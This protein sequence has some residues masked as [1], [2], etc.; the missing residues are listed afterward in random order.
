MSNSFVIDDVCQPWKVIETTLPETLINM[1][2]VHS[3]LIYDA[4]VDDLATHLQ[5]V[6]TTPHSLHSLGGS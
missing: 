6:H 1:F 3:L 5:Q 2:C 4:S